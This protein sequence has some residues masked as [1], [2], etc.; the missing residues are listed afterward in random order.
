[1]VWNIFYFHPCLGKWSN[2]SNIFQMGWNHQ[3]DTHRCFSWIW[4]SRNGIQVLMK[5][6]YVLWPQKLSLSFFQNEHLGSP[7]VAM[8]QFKSPWLRFVRFAGHDEKRVKWMK[9][10][11]P[12]RSFRDGIYTKRIKKVCF[13]GSSWSF[14]HHLFHVFLVQ[15]AG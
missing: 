8:S 7:R 6:C 15:D 13:S 14:G 11:T 10:K 5:L 2:L 1:M 3:L 12:K 4:N 9:T